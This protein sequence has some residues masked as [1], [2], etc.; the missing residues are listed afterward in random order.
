MRKAGGTPAQWQ[1]LADGA[2]ARGEIPWNSK[3]VPPRPPMLPVFGNVRAWMM[4]PATSSASGRGRRRRPRPALM[5]RE[6]AEVRRTSSGHARGAGRCQQVGRR[7]RH[8]DAA[9]PLEFHRAPYVREAR[10]QR[11]ARGADVRAAEHGA[12][13]CRGRLLGR[14][15][16]LL[17]PASLAARSGPQ[18]GDRPSELPVLHLRT[19]DVLG[20]GRRGVV[21]S[22]SSDAADFEAQKEEASISRLYG[23]I[24]YRS[25]LEVG[26][27]HGKRIGGY[28]VRFARLD[29]ADAR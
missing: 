24:H 13:R 17:Q 2:T 9:R 20:R 1:A 19:L 25:D 6:V 5:A 26:K 27:A 8:A 3:D 11:G 28:T 14:Q 10:I 16:P 29:G 23:G 22:V 7:P 18:D 21:L 15:V 12:A 4:T